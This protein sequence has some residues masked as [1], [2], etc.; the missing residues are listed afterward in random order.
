MFCVPIQKWIRKAQTTGAEKKRENQN[1]NI[2][3]KRER[4]RER[5]RERSEHYQQK[6]GNRGSL[7]RKILKPSA[8]SD[9]PRA[10]ATLQTPR[11]TRSAATE[12][13]KRS[14]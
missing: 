10:G 7:S 14:R 8:A 5:E 6:F 3:N 2:C 1:S 4:E 11:K 9:S 13:R 12:R